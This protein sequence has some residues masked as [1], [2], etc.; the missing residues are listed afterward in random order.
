MTW[1]ERIHDSKPIWGLDNESSTSPEVAIIEPCGDDFHWE[2]WCCRSSNMIA[3]GIEGTL[4]AAKT[5]VELNIVK[6]PHP[7]S[8]T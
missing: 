5:A 3:H 4:E 2:I 8:A 7:C 6:D 1:T